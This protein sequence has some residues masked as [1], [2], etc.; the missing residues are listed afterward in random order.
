[1]I[2]NKV[3]SLLLRQGIAVTPST[4]REEILSL[5]SELRPVRTP[6]PLI[7]LGP[8]TDGGYLVPDDLD[9][10]AACFSPGVSRVAGFEKDCALRGM[11]VYLADR[12]IETL[13]E[14][15]PKFHF[16]KKFIGASAND[17][18]ITPEQWVNSCHPKP[19][20]DLIL[21]MDI[22]GYEY[23]TILSMP[24]PLIRRFRI[25]VTE[26]HSVHLWWSRP[27][28]E[29]SRSAIRKILQTHAV[30]HIHP[31]NI[32]KLIVRQG[33]ALP[34]LPEITFLRRDRI[35]EKERIRCLPHPLDISNT[36]GPQIVL[37]P[38]W[39]RE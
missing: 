37:P 14:E 24:E 16:L 15:D 10:I 3:I 20:D 38:Y 2:R 28:F 21:Q 23:E 19:D 11:E 12:S 18:F 25:I 31:N 29:I 30:V 4:R 9:G 8:G 6:S 39:Y 27:F 22:E 13:P 7:R 34:E 26:F 35:P 36:G 32:G 33:V 5:I 1:M 17:D